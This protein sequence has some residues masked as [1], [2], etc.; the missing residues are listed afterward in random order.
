MRIV[1]DTNVLVSGIFWGGAPLK[2][3]D[4]WVS[5][6]LDIFTTMQIL[7][8]YV[9]VINA[10]GSRKPALAARWVDLLTTYPVVIKN[11]VSI[12]R[13]RDPDD[14]K[15]LECAVSADVDCIVSGDDDLLALKHIH[16]IP[17]LKPSAFISRFFAHPE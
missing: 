2:I 14:N 12:S 17:I 16:T 5:G 3:L 13:S 10:L 9:R 6:D 15:F 1:L 7:D 4:H 8:E 11:R